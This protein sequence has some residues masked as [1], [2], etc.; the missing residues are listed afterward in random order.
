MRYQ[1]SFAI[2]LCIGLSLQGCGRKGPLI[3]P[4]S[5]RPFIQSLTPA[6]SSIPAIP[7]AK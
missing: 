4:V 5:Q 1:I 3:M 6:A 2:I 7:T